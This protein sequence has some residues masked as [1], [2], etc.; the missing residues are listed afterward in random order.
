MQQTE[1][2]KEAIHKMVEMLEATANIA[3]SSHEA[4]KASLSQEQIARYEHLSLSVCFALLEAS[5]LD[6]MV[7]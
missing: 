2:T 3:R 7:P 5:E 4:A 1:L 6:S